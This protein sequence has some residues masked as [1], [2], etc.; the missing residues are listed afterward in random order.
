MLQSHNLTYLVLDDSDYGCTGLL[1]MP[2]ADSLVSHLGGAG[3][4]LR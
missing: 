1:A 2:L 4:T 3:R